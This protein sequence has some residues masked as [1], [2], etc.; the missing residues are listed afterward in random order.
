MLVWEVQCD[1]MGAESDYTREMSGCNGDPL[2]PF[3]GMLRK[4]RRYRDP[5]HRCPARYEAFG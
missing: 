2:R 4:H 1:W 3:L 5:R